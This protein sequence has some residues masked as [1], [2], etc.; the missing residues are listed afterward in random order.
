MSSKKPT[1]SVIVRTFNEERWIAHLL[2]AIF[3]Q[4]FDYFEIIIVDNNST[5]FTVDIAKR[6]PIEKIIMIDKFLPGKALNDGI[7]QSLGEFI[8]CVSAHCIPKDKYWLKNLH[9]NFNGNKQYAGVYGRQLPYLI[10]VTL[11]KETY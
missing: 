1:V 2:N 5:D 10:Q 4:E 9:K 6:F 11:T 7:R 8:V 3:S